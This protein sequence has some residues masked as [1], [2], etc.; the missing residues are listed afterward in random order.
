V[1]DAKELRQQLDRAHRQLDE[2]ASRLQEAEEQRAEEEAI[3][4]RVIEQVD[5]LEK[6]LQR[7]V[8]ER[9]TFEQ[10]L[11]QYQ[12]DSEST[13]TELS[14]VA[15]RL[16][17]E[18]RD[19]EKRARLLEQELGQL[20][21]DH[22]QLGQRAGVLAGERDSVTGQLEDSRHELEGLRQQLASREGDLSG[23]TEGLN[24]ELETERQQRR[25]L[26]HEMA[27]L[28]AER[29]R[30]ESVLAEAQEREQG[31]QDELQTAQEQSQSAL[32]TAHSEAS[33]AAQALQTRIAELQ[34]ELESRH[35]ELQAQQDQRGELESRVQAAE[36]ALAEAQEREQGLQDELQRA[37]QAADAQQQKRKI[38]VEDAESLRDELH[39][40]QRKQAASEKLIAELEQ[41]VTDSAA[42]HK[43]DISSVRDALTRA[44]DERENVRRDQKRL[45]ESLRKAERQLERERQDHEAEVHRLRKELKQTA[46]ESNAGL[47]AELEALQKKLQEELTHRQDLEISLGERS[48]QLE[49]VQAQQERLAKQLE[50]ARCSAREAEQQ[51]VE[52]TQSANEE[53]AVRLNAEQEAQQ[54]LRLEL[55][56]TA[57][58][59]D[60]QQAQLSLLTQESMQMREALECD[61]EQTRQ[62]LEEL[63]E[64][65]R[66]AERE[67]NA[68]MNAE[69]ALRE[70]N[71]RL[72][73]DAEVNRGLET[74]VSSGGGEEALAQELEQARDHANRA[75]HERADAQQ[76]L[77]EVQ[78]E[79]ERL[80]AELA[81]QADE[82]SCE[83]EPVEIIS[84]DETDV[85]VDGALQ[86][87]L[88]DVKSGTDSAVPEPLLLDDDSATATAEQPPDA[89]RRALPRVLLG[90][91]LLAS[92]GAAVLGWSGWWSQGGHAWPEPESQVSPEAVVPLEAESAD[93]SDRMAPPAE[94]ELDAASQPEVV[95]ERPE[96]AGFKVPT[97]DDYG[98]QDSGTAEPRALVEQ[99]P[100]SL[101]GAVPTE[102]TSPATRQPGA[103]F[104]D[105]LSTG[106][107]GPSM[108]ELYAD[109]FEMGGGPTSPNFD[110]RPRHPVSLKRFAMSK[111]EITFRD[112]D[113]FA[114]ATG[115]PRP[116]STGPGRAARPVVN[117][118]WR[119]AVAYT[120]WLS[121]QTGHS[122]R[123]PSEAEWEFAA[124]SG[125]ISRYWWGN[126]V[127]EANANCFDC[128]SEWS[129]RE[130]APVGS[131]PASPFGL[132][133]LAGNVREWVQDC[134]VAGYE[135]A[136][137]DGRAVDSPRCEQRVVRGG[138]FASASPK[139]RVTTRDQAE[140]DTRLDDLGFR[141]VREYR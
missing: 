57:R 17:Q 81:G 89:S 106:E 121:A 71:D 96:F 41:R 65:L 129:G 134:Y 80:R 72:R 19:H 107:S 33:G 29:T 125:T 52:A 98:K 86:S 78:G 140:P 6:D 138:S 132:H 73:A 45:M 74:M 99:E 117:V 24:R 55:K 1:P 141:V 22:K 26:E 119:D 51:L 104:S 79:V 64:K 83:P 63:R 67:R 123:L 13:E 15:G 116:R 109:S 20:R 82:L 92:L 49:D 37:E 7:A 61:R 108:L 9:A 91:L 53:M 137:A 12:A 114:R 30:L 34:A 3:S 93:E 95:D 105:R 60:E 85:P 54:A 88:S 46:G 130:T 113:R 103:A 100:E 43:S 87:G 16:E 124:R 133:D 122:Y 8:D 118:S 32:E 76:Q 115:R 120:E 110:E 102:V 70:Q 21:E 4:T 27:A 5:V 126:E 28:G 75:M 23:Q 58:E 25:R 10:Q 47:A 18:R 42:D 97:S 56:R 50:Q 127:G 2:L 139:L 62:L 77:L 66:S 11:R 101:V 14:Q 131:F 94:L 68:A 84:L 136:P 48:A 36:Q 39:E 112:Y 40:A 38:A 44:Q 128:G 111:N 31:L 69:Q 90:T 35:G 135:N 59:R